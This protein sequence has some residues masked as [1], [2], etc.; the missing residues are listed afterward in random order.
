MF[1]RV[2]ESYARDPDEIGGVSAY[3]NAATNGANGANLL[4]SQV[5]VKG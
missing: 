5:H 3:E 4:A 1:T 2:K